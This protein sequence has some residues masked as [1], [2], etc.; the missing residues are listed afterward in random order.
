MQ[1]SNHSLSAADKSEYGMRI[2]GLMT[3]RSAT[4][5]TFPIMGFLDPS[6]PGMAE[7]REQVNARAPGTALAS[8]P[9]VC[10]AASLWPTSDGPL[11]KNK[12]GTVPG[13]DVVTFESATQPPG[14]DEEHLFV[15]KTRRVQ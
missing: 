11:I 9:F 8:V 10:V 15:L 5:K 4:L 3:V 13:D 14:V 1:R 7:W 6:K 12:R 2:M